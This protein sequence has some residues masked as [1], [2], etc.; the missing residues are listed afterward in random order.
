MVFDH[1]NKKYFYPVLVLLVLATLIAFGR[2]TGNDFINFDDNKYITENSNILLGINLQNIKWATTAIVVSNWHPL[3]LLSHMLDWSLFGSN[4]AGHHLVSLLLHIGAVILLFLFLYKTTNHLWPSAF[5]AAFFALH[6]LR[7]ESVAWAAERKDVLSMFFAMATLYT[8]AFYV[9]NRKISKYLLCLILFALALMSKPMMVTL[10]FVLLLLDYWPLKRLDSL[11]T[12][13]NDLLKKAGRLLSE[14]IPFFILTALAVFI[15]YRTHNVEGLA[16]SFNFAPISTRC[17][18][19]LISYFAYLGKTFWPANL[20]VYYPYDL[21]FA[22]G[23]IAVPVIIIFLISA[24]VLYNLK[25]LPFL[26]VGWSWYLGTLIPVIGLIQ[27][28]SQAMADRYT[29]LP[30]VGI[31]IMLAWLLPVFFKDTGFRKKILL[32]AAIILL[33]LLSC[34]TWRQC[35]YWKNSM[36]LFRHALQVT[37]NNY[38]AHNHLA[39]ALLKEN[40]FDQ[41]LYHYGEAVRIHPLYAHAYL[42]RGMAYYLFGSKQSALN[43]FREAVRLIPQTA[44][45]A[46]AYNNLGAAYSD[47]GQY[48]SAIASYSLAIHL[49]PDYADAYSNRAFAN[50]AVGNTASGCRD[51]QKA[52]ALGNCRTFTSA[53]KK[54]LCP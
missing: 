51:A 14:K 10:P 22:L 42:N 38:I 48:Q 52:C 50:L 47:L 27:V 18:N 30:S 24:C 45:Y 25:K 20:A 33:V 7:V 11:S 5:A 34:L 15:T 9:E 19:A 54:N 43:D 1:M 49:K 46:T 26:F 8:Y 16:Q 4:A 31:S 35:G 3:T 41:A 53:Q 39:S 17:A 36:T 12:A 29:Y 40:R 6:P 44:E 13:N 2:T 23:M 32:P 37:E 21:N 28:G